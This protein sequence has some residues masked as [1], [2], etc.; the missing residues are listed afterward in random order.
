MNYF[1]FGIDG[2]SYHLIQNLGEKSLPNLFSL[3]KNGVYGELIS[4]TPPHT[5]PGWASA[6]TGCSPGTHGIYQFFKTQPDFMEGFM[7]SR[8]LSVPAVWE[9]LNK[10]NIST[11]LINIPMTYP[12]DKVNGYMLAWPLSRTLRYSYPKNLLK[13]L[14]DNGGHYLP[15]IYAMFNGELSYIEEAVAIIHKRVK[16]VKYLMKK[17]PQDFLMAVFPEVDRISHFYWSFM[18]EK[19]HC[20]PSLKY[21][22]QRIYEETDKALGL[23]LNELDENCIKVILSDHGFGKGRVD[24]YINYFLYTNHLLGIIEA[25][26]EDKL[27]DITV[28][29]LKHKK[30]KID[31][32]KTVAYMA[33]PGSYGININR[34]GRQRSGIID[35]CDYESVCRQVI[36]LLSGVKDP[37]GRLLFKEVLMAKDVYHGEQVIN[38]PDIILIPESYGTMVQHKF[39]GQFF[40]E[41][42]QKGMHRKEGFYIISG[43]KIKKGFCHKAHIEDITPTILHLQGIQP[44]DYMEG[45]PIPVMDIAPD[46]IPVKGLYEGDILKQRSSTRFDNCY[47]KQEEKEIAD[48]LKSLGYL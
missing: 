26:E 44:P 32:D 23:L 36:G 31:W 21:A 35:A 2:G 19:S 47:S 5:A 8:D 22:V 7:G 14:M 24:F 11:G 48:R 4:T 25:G 10:A 15:D 40:G 9:I 41:P 13:E 20:T 30:M 1:V 46:M 38:A 39:G 16:S 17:Y 34:K 28:F 29:S 27:D 6:V 43:K 45:T 3:M 12:P 18:E 37:D 42:E 33:A